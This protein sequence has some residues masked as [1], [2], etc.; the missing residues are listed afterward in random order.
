MIKMLKAII[1]D[2]DGVTPKSLN[3]FLNGAFEA[4]AYPIPNY[5]A[6][7]GHGVHLY[8]LFEYA[9][10]LYPNIKMQLKAFK[11]AIIVSG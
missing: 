6:L 8:Y 2:L 5:I 1:F 10:P 9:I 11:Y 7:S 3:A 4:D